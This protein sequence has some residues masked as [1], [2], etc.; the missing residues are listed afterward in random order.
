MMQNQLSTFQ[1]GN[2]VRN[3]K[4]GRIGTITCTGITIARVRFDEHTNVA[5]WVRDLTP[6]T[7][8][9]PM[10]LRANAVG[11]ATIILLRAGQAA[12]DA[13]YLDLAESCERAARWICTGRSNTAELNCSQWPMWSAL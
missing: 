3:E 7:V 8:T 6:V 11:N 12:N 13:G 2:V 10:N 9:V 4:T 1:V 5:C